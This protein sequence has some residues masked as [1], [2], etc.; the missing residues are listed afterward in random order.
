MITYRRLGRNGQLGNQLWQIASTIGIARQKGEAPG[1]P[2][3]RYQSYFS[4]PDDF[5]G[6]M[7]V[8]SH[9]LG[10]D[11]LQDL[12]YLQGIEDEVRR[13][14]RPR[15]DLWDRLARR[16]D[17][18]LSLRHKTAVHVRRGDYL[19]NPQN[20]ISL[21]VE[22]YVEAM[23][24][25]RG[26]YMVFSDDLDWCRANL[27]GD[28]YFMEHNTNVE[29]LCLMAACDEHITANST[30]SWWGAWL[31]DTRAVYPRQWGAIFGDD[32]ERIMPEGAIV[33]DVPVPPDCVA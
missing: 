22:Y 33:L 23:E 4:V 17:S 21:P 31:A 3:W 16:F 15:S 9:D 5:F 8:Q 26:P 27:P 30:F 24:L 6:L 28:C 20:F 18:L 13:Y 11:Y 12:K 2:F 10:L 32:I 14:F 1:F 25:T 29:D 19:D 7:D